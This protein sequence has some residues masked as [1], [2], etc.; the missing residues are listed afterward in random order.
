MLLAFSS[1][2]VIVDPLAAVP[3]FIAMTPSDTPAERIRM[4]R[5]ACWVMA[6]VLLSF[7]LAG[8]LIF[9]LL[10]ITPPAIDGLARA[11]LVPADPRRMLCWVQGA[12]WQ[13]AR[14]ISHDGGET[15]APIKIQPG[16]VRGVLDLPKANDAAL[17]MAGWAI[18]ENNHCPAEFVLL[19]AKGQ[20]VEKLPIGSSR[21]DIAD[22]LGKEYLK[23]G[24]SG[25]YPAALFAKGDA[26]AF[27]V[28]GNRASE[29]KYTYEPSPG[30][31]ELKDAPFVFDAGLKVMV[32]S[33]PVAKNPVAAAPTATPAAAKTTTQYSLRKT[34]DAVTAIV[35]SSGG[36]VL[37]V[38]PD[39]VR[40]VLDQP[41]ARGAAL[42][43]KG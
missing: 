18:D 4:A 24:F 36:T 38:Q 19:F 14:Y 40:G 21:T 5:L 22:W 7:A 2:F 16:A 8:K 6:G 32:P 31:Y 33:A 10:G 43:I 9:K 29:V 20:F 12:N 39:A 30:K 17:V 11:D 15:F 37:A 34:G 25:K 13:W 35:A 27:A 26:R 28:I 3:A 23:S 41:K 42:G 1:L